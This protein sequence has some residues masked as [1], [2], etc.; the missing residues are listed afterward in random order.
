M[1]AK[2]GAVVLAAGRSSRFGGAH[3]LLAEWQGRPVIG[4][5]IDAIAA[6]GLPPPLV[7]L[8]HGAADVR[9]ALAG[10]DVQFV[11]AP[12]WAEGMGRSLAAGIAAVP[13]AWDAALVCLADM[14]AIEPALIAAIASAPGDIVLPVWGGKRGHP[15]RWPR[16][17]FAGLMALTGDSGGKALMTDH[18]ITEIAAPSPACLADVDTPEALQALTGG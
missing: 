10:R 11:T 18:G 7:V 13:P 15:V 12:D 14:P 17:A 16:R 9:A 8:G 4:H 2:L 5:V 1:P 3:K 6:A